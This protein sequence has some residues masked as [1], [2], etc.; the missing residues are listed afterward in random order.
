MGATSLG[1]AVLAVDKNGEPTSLLDMGVRIF[2][3][4]RDDKEKEPLS[5]TRRGARGTRR[6]LDRTK[7]RQKMLMD[8][9]VEIGLMPD[10]RKAR[11]NLEVKDPY[12]IKKKAVDERLEVYELGR[13]LFHLSKRRGFKSNRKTDRKAAEKGA[14]NT[15]SKNLK[16]LLENYK[17]FGEFL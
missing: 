5:V 17:S 9:M 12:E 6:R 15:A 2:P 11:K 3:D 7:K 4:G 8:F 10:N 16:E 1:W 13:A 14:I